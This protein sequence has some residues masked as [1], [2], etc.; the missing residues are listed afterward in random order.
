MQANVNTRERKH[1]RKKWSRVTCLT[2]P[3]AAAQ[4]LESQVIEDSQSHWRLTIVIQ[5]KQ[6]QTNK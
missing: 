1:I 5:N 3:L 6:L 4:S 2:L